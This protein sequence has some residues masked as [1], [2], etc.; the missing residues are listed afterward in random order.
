MTW[1][2]ANLWKTSKYLDWGSGFILW[3]SVFYPPLSPMTVSTKT[4]FL[5]ASVFHFCIF[6][7]VLLDC[8]PSQAH[9]TSYKKQNFQSCNSKGRKAQ[10]DCPDSPRQYTGGPRQSEFFRSLFVF[11]QEVRKRKER[12]CIYFF[13][14]WGVNL[15]NKVLNVMMMNTTVLHETVSNLKL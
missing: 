2:P 7:K 1:G 3:W 10:E 15:S 8:E 9:P 11:F 5:L 12:F 13:L 4:Q 14:N 6:G